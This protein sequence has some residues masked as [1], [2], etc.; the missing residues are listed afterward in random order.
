MDIIQ[1]LLLNCVFFKE[2]DTVL[3]DW[4]LFFNNKGIAVLIHYSAKLNIS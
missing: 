2:S 4:Y 1:F 3:F